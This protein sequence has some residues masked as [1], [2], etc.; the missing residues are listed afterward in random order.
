M[1]AAPI[2]GGKDSVVLL[3]HLFE[4]NKLNNIKVFSFHTKERCKEIDDVFKKLEKRFGISIEP[5]YG[6]DLK[7]CTWKMVGKYPNIY[8]VYMGVRLGDSK[9]ITK[10]HQQSQ[11]G[12]PPLE[13]IYPIFNL[14]YQ[15]VWQ[16]INDNNLPACDLYFKGYSSLGENL[17]DSTINPNLFNV[18]GTFKKPWELNKFYSERFGRDNLEIYVSGVVIKGNQI[19]RTIKFPTANIKTTQDIT[20]GIYACLIHIQGKTYKGV[21]SNGYRPTI[22]NFEEP[23][24]ETHIF[25]FSDDLYDKTITIILKH[26]I[27]HENKFNDINELIDVMKL[28]CKLAKILLNKY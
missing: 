11:N 16:I 17:Q 27:R 26:Y 28:D 1:E 22:G 25:D 20:I 5:I 14:S 19:G 6:K 21:S 7:E 10:D 2:T 23:I 18:D 9:Y 8:R 24:L 15:D 3:H 12:Y 4:I 13:L